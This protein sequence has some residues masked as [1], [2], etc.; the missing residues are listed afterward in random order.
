MRAVEGVSLMTDA[1]DIGYVILG[2]LV[3]V[4]WIGG[5][6]GARHNFRD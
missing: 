4:L 1:S 3:V 6:I 2:L 5:L